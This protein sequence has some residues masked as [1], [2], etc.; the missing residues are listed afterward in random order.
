M[1]YNSHTDVTSTTVMD[2]WGGVWLGRLM[3]QFMNFSMTL[4]NS[5]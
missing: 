1:A 2:I 3:I 4:T 5:M